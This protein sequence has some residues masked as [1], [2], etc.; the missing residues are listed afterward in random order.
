MEDDILQVEKGIGGQ[1]AERE[2]GIW[3]DYGEEEA[4][5]HSKMGIVAF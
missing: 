4:M 5:G 3:N 1:I 2:L